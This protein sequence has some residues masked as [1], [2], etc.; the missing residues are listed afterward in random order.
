MNTV[1]YRGDTKKIDIE[2]EVFNATI[3]GAHDNVIGEG[4]VYTVLF[5]DIIGSLNKDAVY[6]KEVENIPL[7]MEQERKSF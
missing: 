4:M 3:E 5:S 2:V 1:Y 7:E 6:M